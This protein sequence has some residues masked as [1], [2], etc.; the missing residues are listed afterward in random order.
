VLVVIAAW[1]RVPTTLNVRAAFGVAGCR[2]TYVRKLT[3]GID[4]IKSLWEDWIAPRVA[5]HRLPASG[6][7]IGIFW[8]LLVLYCAAAVA[9][10]LP[11]DGEQLVMLII[12]FARVGWVAKV[13]C[14]PSLPSGGDW[15]F[16]SWRWWVTFYCP[17]SSTCG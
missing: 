16:P 4:E 11:I 2:C 17:G 15:R 12:L 14:S 9:V 1:Q 13:Y 7:R 10:N 8:L 5:Q 3:E 6:K